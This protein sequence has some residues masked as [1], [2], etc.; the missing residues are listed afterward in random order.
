METIICWSKAVTRRFNAG[1]NAILHSRNHWVRS[2]IV[3][4]FFFLSVESSAAVLATLSDAKFSKPFSSIQTNRFQRSHSVVRHLLWNPCQLLDIQVHW[5][6]R[7][8]EG[9]ARLEFVI[10]HRSL[11]WCSKNRP[12][13]KRGK[14]VL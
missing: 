9:E 1:E 6:N 5:Q 3:P 13:Q 4:F 14:F 11:R 2:P 8:N 10:N 7:V 12:C